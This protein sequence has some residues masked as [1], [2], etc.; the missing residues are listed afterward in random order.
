MLQLILEFKNLAEK[1]IEIGKSKKLPTYSD[2][3]PNTK[4]VDNQVLKQLEENLM[5]RK[6]I[7]LH[8]LSWVSHQPIVVKLFKQIEEAPFFTKY[9]NK[10][11]VGYKEDKRVII[12]IL[13][14]IILESDDLHLALEEH[15]IFWY[16]DFDYVIKAVINT[17]NFYEKGE[18][19]NKRLLP[20]YN[21]PDDEEFL[22]DIFRKSLLNYEENTE[23]I[24]KY[25]KNWDFDRIAI[26]DSIILNMALCEFMHFPSIPTKVTLNE[27]VELSKYFST[28]KSSHFINGVLDRILKDYLKEDKI[29]KMGRGLIG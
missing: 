9:M 8:R 6:H 12:D 1:K 15:S 13:K 23:V 16:S 25:A 10:E 3:N 5:L 21:K 4:F 18:G 7:G 17:I 28:K 20:L 11:N 14:D 24:S 29:G 22:T 19:D 2:L 27:Y 26:I